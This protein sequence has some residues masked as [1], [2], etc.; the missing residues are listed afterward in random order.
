[1]QK[2]IVLAY[3]GGLQSTVALS[4]LI[5]RHDA[6]VV[7]VTVDLGQSAD[8]VGARDRAL[9]AGAVRSHVI[10]GRED[11]MRDV[12]VPTLKADGL[13]DAR[14]PMATGMGRPVIAA[15]LAEFAGIED[16]A[17]V[18]HGGVGRDRARLEALV[19]GRDGTL[20]VVACAAEHGFTRQ[21]AIDY[22]AQRPG[23]S[24]VE[25]DERSRTDANLWGIT[26]GRRADDPA[27]E[28]PE[29]IFT[30]TRP[31]AQCPDQP[32][33]VAVAFERGVPAGINGVKMSMV[34]LVESLS[35]IAGEHGVGRLDRI[36]CRPDGTRVRAV[37]EAPAAVVLH[38]AH[39]EL[40]RFVSPGPLN[41]FSRTV[42]AVYADLIGRG[43]WFS[44]L[45]SALDAFVDRA[46]EPATGVI[47]LRLFKGS[48]EVIGREPS[49]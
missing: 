49:C 20:I 46:N 28:V 31:V 37:Y 22:A 5:D 34:E 14:Y 17:I 4:W 45:R 12:V 13:S 3:S 10:D 6:E 38:R 35:T 26:T 44:P 43:E 40:T 21:Q 29:A 30:R 8:L 27:H 32:A 18:A 15:K 33:D 39:L 9:A 1:M 19:R 24:P 41:A 23:A 2:R 16:A 11:F 25:D 36:K 42:S 47:R 48:C 7:T